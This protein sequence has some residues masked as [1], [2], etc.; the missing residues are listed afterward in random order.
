MILPVLPSQEQVTKAFE[1]IEQGRINVLRPLLYI[2]PKSF[3]SV[4]HPDGSGATL[5]HTATKLNQLE[6]LGDLLKKNFPVDA[7]DENGRNPLHL[8]HTANAAMMLLQAAKASGPSMLLEQDFEGNLPFHSAAQRGRAHALAYLLRVSPSLSAVL[9]RTNRLG[10]TVMHELAMHAP[11]LMPATIFLGLDVRTKNLA[12]KT[13]QDVCATP[14]G[15]TLLGAHMVL[16]DQSEN[17]AR[18]ALLAQMKSD[19]TIKAAEKA[20]DYLK[21]S[22]PV[23]SSFF[24]KK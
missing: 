2:S 14:E 16:K 8:V 23:A 21:A 1:A 19:E 9:L 5:V 10:D 22:T 11:S 7:I 3:H 24:I 12:G 18:E 20:L 15:K 6:V 17:I 4:T 13:A